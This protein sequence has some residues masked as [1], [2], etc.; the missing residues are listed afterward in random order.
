MCWENYNLETIPPRVLPDKNA[1]F[2]VDLAS[3]LYG[4]PPHGYFGWLATRE[5]VVVGILPVVGVDIFIAA[6]QKTTLSCLPCAEPL[7]YYRTLSLSQK[8]I[9]LFSFF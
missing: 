1:P 5:A 4:F 9:R 3:C 8:Y 2:A 7:P 6:V